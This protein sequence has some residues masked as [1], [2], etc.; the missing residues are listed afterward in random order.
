M[1]GVVLL[2]E[3]LQ[4]HLRSISKVY[5]RW[6]PSDTLTHTYYQIESCSSVYI[7]SRKKAVGGNDIHTH[8]CCLNKVGWCKTANIPSPSTHHGFVKMRFYKIPPANKYSPSVSTNSFIIM[9]KNCNNKREKHN[10]IVMNL[11]LSVS[12]PPSLLYIHVH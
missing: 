4:Q 12:L 11:F 5:T 1:H 7:Q 3:R 10:K 8:S 9:I 2:T 6:L